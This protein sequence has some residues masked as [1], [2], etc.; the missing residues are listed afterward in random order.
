MTYVPRTLQFVTEATVRARSRED[1][2]R[3]AAEHARR[4]GGR[5]LASIYH[6]PKS[7]TYSFGMKSKSTGGAGAPKGAKVVYRIRKSGEILGP[8][9][10]SKAV[11]A[12][13]ASRL[14]K[15][16]SRIQRSSRLSPEE[17]QEYERAAQKARGRTPIPGDV[18]R[19]V[20]QTIGGMTPGRPE[21]KPQI[22]GVKADARTRT[23]RALSWVRKKMGLAKRDRA[24]GA[25]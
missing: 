8:D 9:E 10:R 12:G 3:S 17:K 24:A 15:Q 1:A 4:L 6:D 16:L 14:E 11:R 7:D 5:N 23:Q 18:R 2:I 21:S 22:V 19:A 20:R 25:A 13:R